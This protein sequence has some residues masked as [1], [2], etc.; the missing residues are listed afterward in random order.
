MFYNFEKPTTQ[1][2]KTY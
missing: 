1:H 2:T